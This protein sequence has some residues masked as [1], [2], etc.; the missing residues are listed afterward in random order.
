MAGFRY[1]N[2]TIPGLPVDT[3]LPEGGGDAREQMSG[4]PIGGERN[5][6]RDATGGIVTRGEF[7][8]EVKE[9]PLPLSE[10]LASRRRCG[11]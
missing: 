10:G 11:Y 2:V 4:P 5:F 3:G 9:K 8:P 1:G 6:E 7:E